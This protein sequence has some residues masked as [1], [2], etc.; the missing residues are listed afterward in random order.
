MKMENNRPAIN[1]KLYDCVKVNAS[2]LE[3][4][5]RIYRAIRRELYYNL[6]LYPFASKKHR[7]LV[8]S[9]QKSQSHLYTSFYRS[10]GQ[11]SALIGPVLEF[12]LENRKTR[13]TDKL[14]INVL[15]GSDGSEAYTIASVLCN[16]CPNLDFHIHCSDLHEQTVTKSQS[17][18]YSKEEVFNSNTPEKFISDTFDRIN[19]NFTVKPHIK[20][21]VTFFKADITH[22]LT[23]LYPKADIVFMQNVLFH[24][25]TQS[26]TNAFMNA[27][28]IS[29][30]RCVFFLD[31]TPINLKIKLTEK[32]NLSPLNHK[33][34]AIHEYAR[35]H[36]AINWWDYYYGVEP[37]LFFKRDKKRRYSTI[38]FRQDNSK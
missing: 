29:K 36:V 15:A 38:F 37:Y 30:P 1:T 25:D 35:L 4:A 26:A 10:P 27:L 31:G 28:E 14:Q 21:K 32:S 2:I 8:N 33:I 18:I 22:N 7:Q 5:K 13:P 24:L 9:A 12:I 23:G 16:L 19:S 20:E 11:M 17:A 6:M 34:K 3:Q